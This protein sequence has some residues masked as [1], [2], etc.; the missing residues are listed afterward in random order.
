MSANSEAIF[1]PFDTE[2]GGIGPDVSLLTAHF[3]ICDANWN[4]LAELYLAMKPNDGIYKT[5]AEALTINKIDLINHD[6]IALTYSESGARLRDFIKLHSQDGKI[7]LQPM[8][9]NVAFDVLKVTDNI[10]GAKTF[11]QYVSYRCYD[12]TPLVTFLKRTKRLELNAPESLSGLAEYF[13]ITAKW[14]TADGDNKAGIEVMK[15]L[16]SL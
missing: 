7:K 11:N 5:T 6:K 9:K 4:I 16:E 1:L 3:A 2:T 12:I 15:I 8:G 13:G 10:L 14:H